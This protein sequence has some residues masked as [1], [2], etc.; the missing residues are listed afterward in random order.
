MDTTPIYRFP[1]PE[2]DPPLVKDASQIVQV[3]DLAVAVDTVVEDVADRGDLAIVAPQTVRIS[4]SV[5]VASTLNTVVPVW[6]SV[7][8]NPYLMLD[9]SNIIRPNETGW[10]QVGGYVNADS[11]AAIAAQ[12]RFTLDGD[13]VTS[14]SDESAVYVAQLQLPYLSVMLRINAG[15]ALNMEVHHSTGGAPSWTHRAFMWAWKV[16]AA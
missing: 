4:Q 12:I 6:N 7:Q 9:G 14:W 10:W 15:Q 11:A 8:F 3:R 2:C 16:I 1:Y 13:P 5:A